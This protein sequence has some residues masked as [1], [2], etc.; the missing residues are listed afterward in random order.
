MPSH[1]VPTTHPRRALLPLLALLLTAQSVVV[2]SAAAQTYFP[3]RHPDWERRTP[4]QAGFDPAGIAR[5]VEIAIAGESQSPRDLAFNHLGTFGREPLGDAVGPFTVRGPQSGV[6]VH[7]GYIIA[8]WGDPAKADNTFS[9]SKS[10]LSSTV[11]LARDRGLIRSVDDKVRDYI[12]PIIL[13]TG[14]GEPGDENGRRPK[15][16]FESEHNRKITWDHL[17]RQTSDWEGTLWGKPEWADRPD[18]DRSTWGT[19]PRNEPGTAY[20]YN[21]T[22]VN[23]LALAATAV[24]RRPLP[25]VLREHIMDPIGA[26]ST[27]GW[28]GYDNSWVILDGREVQAVSGGAHWGGGMILSAY[29]QARFGLFTMHKGNWSG[30]QLLSEDWFDMATTPGEVN[31]SYGFMNFSLNTD[32]RRYPNAPEY[33]WT[34]TGAGSNLIY[35]DPENELV[36]VCRWIRGGAFTDVVHTVLEAMA[37]AASPR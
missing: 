12:P 31:R 10:F 11:G 4:E 14:D 27:W 36:I 1:S 18:Q 17:L 20:E 9:V 13:D 29:D 8:E 21:D 15:L 25:E 19:R 30:K 28:H 33:T 23:L 7:R 32:Q 26:S 35:V 24:W 6:I 16:L 2:Q 37:P 22:R 3:G 5:A 34:H